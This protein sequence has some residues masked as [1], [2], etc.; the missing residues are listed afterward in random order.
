MR[1]KKVCARTPAPFLDPIHACLPKPHHLVQ[2]KNSLGLINPWFQPF[3]CP[4][5]SISCDFSPPL[6]TRGF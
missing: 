3:W 2:L 6:A 1:C 5:W 4:T